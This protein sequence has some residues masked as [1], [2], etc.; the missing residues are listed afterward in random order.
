MDPV[1][2]FAGIA[3]ARAMLAGKALAAAVVDNSFKNS[4]RSVLMRNHTSPDCLVGNREAQVSPAVF[5][6]RDDSVFIVRLA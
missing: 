3:N 6:L 2:L 5:R 4:R 1:R